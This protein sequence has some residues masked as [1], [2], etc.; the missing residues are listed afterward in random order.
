MSPIKK[1]ENNFS[2]PNLL[3]NLSLSSQF[4]VTMSTMVFGSV[5]NRE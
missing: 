2:G 3:E 4:L 5:L 1:V